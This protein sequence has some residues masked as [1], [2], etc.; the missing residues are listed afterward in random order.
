MRHEQNRPDEALLRD[1]AAY[2]ENTYTPPQRNAPKTVASVDGTPFR[3]A[4]SLMLEEL[5]DAR[6]PAER[7]R[8]RRVG[9][10]K[11][12]FPFGDTAESEEKD[13]APAEAP[14]QHLPRRQSLGSLQE[15]PADEL[16]RRMNALDESFSQ[17]LLRKIDERGIT[18]AACYKRAGVDRKLF[19]KIRGDIRYRPS[20]P[21]AIAFAFALEL[22][23]EETSELLMKA[24]FALS[25]SS[26]SDII[27]EYF[28]QHKIY[29]LMLLNEALLAFD[30]NLIGA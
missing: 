24:G 16:T 12:L 25:H 2:V 18:D 8:R 4:G 7:P 10:A 20:K 11:R 28:I 26:K 22:S 1:L 30:Q 29:D 19:S 15:I 27:V 9:H 17:M 14:K 3:I 21:T 13:A 5:S 23:L 6:E